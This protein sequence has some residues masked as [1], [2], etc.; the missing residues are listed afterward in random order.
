MKCLQNLRVFNSQSKLRNAILT[1]MTTQMITWQ[2]RKKLQEKFSAL[3]TDGDGT[4]TKLELT[5]G[6]K[7][8]YNDIHTAEKEVTK[9]L[10]KI[11]GNEKGGIDFFEFLICATD[12]Q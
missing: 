9:I 4:L 10:S 12:Y 2:E 6:Y 7:S 5:A 3:D 8:I 1:F 11:N